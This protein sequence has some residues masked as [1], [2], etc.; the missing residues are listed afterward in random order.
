MSVCFAGFARF[1]FYGCAVDHRMYR[2]RSS[3]FTIAASI[4]VHVRV[5]DRHVLLDE[6]RPLERDVVEQ[7][8]E[9]GVQAAGAD[10]LGVFVHGLRE[11]GDPVDGISR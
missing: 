3:F 9:D 10:V 1:A 8:L 11:V 5:I 7:L 4:L 6:V 2:D